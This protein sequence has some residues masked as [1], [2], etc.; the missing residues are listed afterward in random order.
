MRRANL[1]GSAGNASAL[2][3]RMIFFIQGDR[4][5]PPPV[6]Q[7]APKQPSGG[8]RRPPI[9][10]TARGAGTKGASGGIIPGRARRVQE[11]GK[12]EKS[13][14][15]P[16]HWPSLL[17]GQRS[18]ERYALRNGRRPLRGGVERNS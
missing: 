17:D 15:E 18:V 7:R 16:V 13:P 11:R 12:F 1:S 2:S 10:V 4:S 5:R 8:P 3:A 14:N 9:A 6:L